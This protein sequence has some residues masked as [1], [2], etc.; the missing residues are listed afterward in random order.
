MSHFKGPHDGIGG[1]IKRC[2]YQAVQQNKVVINTA[3]E[4]A[5]AANIHTQI[6]VLYADKTKIQHPNLDDAVALPGTL[7]V[8]HVKRDGSKLVFKLNSPYSCNNEPEYSSIDYGTRYHIERDPVTDEEAAPGQGSTN[9]DANVIIQLKIGSYYK[10][11]CLVNKKTMNVTSGSRL[12][13]VNK[14]RHQ[15]WP[16]GQSQ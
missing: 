5:D 4:F 3:K 10:V 15:D 2:V 9:Q 16:F 7:K 12:T 14:L 11:K 13:R 6:K 1:T 8:H